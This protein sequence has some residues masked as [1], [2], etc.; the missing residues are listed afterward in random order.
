MGQ[1]HISISSGVC[2]WDLLLDSSYNVISGILSHCA[3][4]SFF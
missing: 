4:I 1:G 3:H 2:R